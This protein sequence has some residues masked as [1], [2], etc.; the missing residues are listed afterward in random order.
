[1]PSSRTASVDELAH[2]VLLAGRDHVI[3]GLVLL[4]HQPLR[5]DVVARVAPVAQRVEIAE[6]EAVLQA[7]L[8]ARERRA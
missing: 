5:L 4:Q 8:D 6:V 3:L 2:R 1:M 7:A